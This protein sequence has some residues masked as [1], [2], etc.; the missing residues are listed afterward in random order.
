[1]SGGI[2]NEPIDENVCTSF[3]TLRE[4][5]SSVS[6]SSVCKS[7]MLIWKNITAQMIDRNVNAMV[8]SS[9]MPTVISSF[10]YGELSCQR[11]ALFMQA[12]VKNV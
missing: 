2:T 10:E 8:D 6:V 11:P 1:M 5:G 9:T 12:K 3:N 4:F 7:A